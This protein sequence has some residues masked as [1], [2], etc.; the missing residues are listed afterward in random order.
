MVN[1]QLGLVGFSITKFLTEFVL[2]IIMNVALK[3]YGDEES[4][5]GQESM[6]EVFTNECRFLVKEFLLLFSKCALQNYLDYLSYECLTI[7]LGVYG[8]Q[9]I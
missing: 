4:Q 5:L 6:F 8:D 3:K 7:M 9:Q 1:F 2:I